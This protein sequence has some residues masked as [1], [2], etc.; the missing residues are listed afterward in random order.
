MDVDAKPTP[1]PSEDAAPPDAKAGVSPRRSD[2]W[3][4]G[5]GAP[6][7][8][9]A[10][11]S[12]TFALLGMVAAAVVAA[13]TAGTAPLD[14]LP[15][16][17]AYVLFGSIPS[18]GVLALVIG[19]A[20]RN[21]SRLRWMAWIGLVLGAILTVGAVAVTVVLIAALRTLG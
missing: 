5:A 11:I 15:D 6:G 1:D 17:A 7:N 4:A 20:G 3:T 2:R 16:R 13:A 9:W 12:V 10:W 21:G 19:L 18:L 8:P 14:R